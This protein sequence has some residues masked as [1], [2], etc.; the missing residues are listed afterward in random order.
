MILLLVFMFVLNCRE[1]SIVPSS[2]ATSGSIVHSWYCYGS[3][4]NQDHWRL[5]VTDKE[6]VRPIWWLSTGPTHTQ[7]KAV[8]VKCGK[9]Q[10]CGEINRLVCLCRS[11]GIHGVRPA[12]KKVFISV[13]VVPEAAWNFE[14]AVDEYCRFAELHPGNNALFKGTYTFESVPI[15]RLSAR[16]I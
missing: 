6:H 5:R 14:T 16:W 4:K 9:F 15:I 12:E 13:W 8:H 2:R 1:T 3:T 10:A 11:T 7:I